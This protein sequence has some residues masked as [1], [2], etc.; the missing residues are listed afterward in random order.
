MCLEENVPKNVHAEQMEGDLKWDGSKNSYCLI[1]QT[2]T[3]SLLRGSDNAL[4]IY[5]S[6]YGPFYAKNKAKY[7]ESQRNPTKGPRI[8]K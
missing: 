5:S 1:R 6:V 8:E 4:S 3:S 2:R 7:A